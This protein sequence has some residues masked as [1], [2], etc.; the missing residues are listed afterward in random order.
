M[1]LTIEIRCVS[2]TKRKERDVMKAVSACE[3]ELINA[4]IEV[5]LEV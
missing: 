1:K 4:N 5:R 2:E 3:M